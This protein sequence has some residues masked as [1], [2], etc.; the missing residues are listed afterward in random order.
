M[1]VD[2]S[3]E[4]IE[5]LGQLAQDISA[6][7]ERTEDVDSFTDTLQTIQTRLSDIEFIL[8]VGK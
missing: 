5:I 7:R 1:D 3:Q 6:I 2:S 8:R 4:I